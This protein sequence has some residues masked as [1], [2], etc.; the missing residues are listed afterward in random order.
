[1]ARE[2]PPSAIAPPSRWEG[3]REDGPRHDAPPALATPTTG[4]SQPSSPRKG[5]EGPD[6]VDACEASAPAPDIQARPRKRRP[7][8]TPTQRAL[9]LLTRREHS[10]KELARKLQA[11]GVA[12]EDADRAIDRLADAGWQDDARF[13]ESLARMRANAGYGPIHIR[14]E[15]G[16]HGLDADA[17]RTALDAIEAEHDWSANARDLVRRRFGAPQGL[18]L[19][20]RRKAADFLL[21]RGFTQD[22]LRAAIRPGPDDDD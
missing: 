15:L 13:A 17:V 7:D 20:R 12:R 8:P 16:T 22:D 11:K 19:A 18:D 3:G 4:R 10:R 9:G 21:R 14:A 6:A 1:M 2:S 5:G